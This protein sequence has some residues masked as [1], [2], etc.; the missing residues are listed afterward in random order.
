MTVDNMQLFVR[1]LKV[2][3]ATRTV[4]GVI[5]NE[6]VDHAGEVFDYESSK[7]H[8][9]KWSSELAKATGGLSV[10]NL[11]V[12]HGNAVAGKL[13]ELTL[14]DVNKA[15]PVVAEVVDDNEWNKVLKGCYTGFSIGGKYAKKWDDPALG[16]KRYTA[17]P[18]EVSLVDLPCN[19]EATFTVHK[20]DGSDD[21]RKFV[22][23]ADPDAADP[24]N[25]PDASVEVIYAD[26]VNKKYPL[27]TDENVRAAWAYIAP[28]AEDSDVRKAVR[29]EFAKRFGEPAALPGCD[30]ADALADAVVAGVLV[31][32]NAGDVFATNAVAAMRKAKGLP[33][34]SKGM[35]DCSSLCCLFRELGWQVSDAKWEA[36]SEGDGSAVP[37]MLLNVLRDLGQAL[38]AMVQEEVAESIALYSSE[39]EIIML[40]KPNEDLEKAMPEGE[41]LAKANA[42]YETLLK[43]VLGELGGNDGDDLAAVAKSLRKQLTDANDGLAKAHAAIHEQNGALNT[44]SKSLADLK[45]KYSDAEQTIAK[46]KSTPAEASTPVLKAIGKDGKVDEIN[47]TGDAGTGNGVEPVKKNGEVDEAAT[48]IKKIHAA[49]GTPMQKRIFGS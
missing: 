20:A 8:F 29:A 19:P 33:E 32:L 15:I 3:E 45:K 46:L 1:L 35:Y 48:A 4:S 34:L 6:A 11:R 36:D 9:A 21:L 38:I 44:L 22:T 30:K 5:A 42:D 31:K 28:A 40:A 26:T 14:D 47:P 24:A 25:A 41:R 37:E 43:A 16:K 23:S 13:N 10:G 7:E 27:D 49:G 17:I 39:P 2:D 18:N 12:M